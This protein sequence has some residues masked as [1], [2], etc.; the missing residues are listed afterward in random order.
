MSLDE[1]YPKESRN[2]TRQL[3]ELL[4]PDRG[5][6][7]HERE[8]VAHVRIFLAEEQPTVAL[9][10]L[11]PLLARTT[12]GQRWDHVIEIR[13]LQALAYQMCHEETQALSALSEAIRL[14]EPEGYIRRFVDEGVS[15]EALLGRLREHQYQHRPTSYVDTLL[16]AF[17]RQSKGLVKPLSKREQ[18]VLQLLAHGTSNEEIAQELLIVVDTVKR[19]ISR[20]FSKLGVQNREQAVKRAKTLG[21][22][23]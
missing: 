2:A 10:R 9:Q 5:L 7:T 1:E 22:L 23:G 19:H 8:E 4:E 3:I 13:L 15:M 20:I 18:E 6:G 11:E 21:L 17:P 14:A 16:A 12:A